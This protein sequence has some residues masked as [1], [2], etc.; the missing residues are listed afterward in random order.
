[1]PGVKIS[2]YQVKPLG[3]LPWGTP[4]LTLSGLDVVTFIIVDAE[5]TNSGTWCIEELGGKRDL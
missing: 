2:D 4:T 3:G 1:M 5:R